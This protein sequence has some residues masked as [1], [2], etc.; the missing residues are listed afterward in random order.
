V[1][2]GKTESVREPEIPAVNPP[3]PEEP[4]ENLAGYFGNIKSIL[5]NHAVGPARGFVFGAFQE[6]PHAKTQKRKGIY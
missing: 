1:K 3:M 5:Y 4:I 6:T 2:A